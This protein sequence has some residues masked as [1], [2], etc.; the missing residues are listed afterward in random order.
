MNFSEELTLLLRACYPLIYVAT[1]EEERLENAIA[2]IIR[3]LGNRNLYIWDFVDGYSDNPNNQGFGKR[4]PLLALEFIE[5]LPSKTGG[6]FILRDFTRFF[7]DIS[8]SRKLRNLA[9]DLKSQPKNIIIIS[10]QIEIPAE[11]AE[12]VTILDFPLPKP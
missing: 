1:T 12:V 9:R 11:L 7:E 4:N 2:E 5:K 8:I 3:P 10:S 6:V